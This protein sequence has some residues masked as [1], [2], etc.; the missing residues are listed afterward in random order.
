MSPPPLPLRTH[1]T[2][3][4]QLAKVVADRFE[5]AS[6]IRSDGCC[7]TGD[8]FEQVPTGHTSPMTRATSGPSWRSSSIPRCCPATL[9]GWHGSPQRRYPHPRRQRRPSKVPGR[10]RQELHPSGESAIR[11][12]ERPLLVLPAQRNPQFDIR[13]RRGGAFGFDPPAPAQRARPFTIPPGRHLPVHGISHPW[14]LAIANSASSPPASVAHAR[15]CSP[16]HRPSPP[17][18]PR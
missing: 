16:A 10:P 15:A 8:V 2:R 13:V 11:A 14:A 3:P 7:E 6:S 5:G 18:A 17:R 9:N 12:R 1:P 4:A